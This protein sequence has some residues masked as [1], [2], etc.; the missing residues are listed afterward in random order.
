[1]ARKFPMRSTPLYANTCKGMAFGRSSPASRTIHFRN[2]RQPDQDGPLRQ[3]VRSP[4][5]KGSIAFRSP[6]RLSATLL[7]KASPSEGVRQRPKARLAPNKP[8]VRPRFRGHRIAPDWAE[9]IPG[10]SQYPLGS[11]PLFSTNN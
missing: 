7:R 9:E 5:D 3:A 6:L 1:M 8:L 10:D 2:Q 4:D 11:V